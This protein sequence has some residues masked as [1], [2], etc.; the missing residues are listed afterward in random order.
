MAQVTWGFQA[1]FS[2]RHL[3]GL[4][5]S[6]QFERFG[7]VTR[8]WLDDMATKWDLI[9]ECADNFDASIWW[10]TTALQ[11]SVPLV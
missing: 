6:V 7:H 5:S 1:E 4:N 3:S 2:R 10:R 9:V 11:F 8:Q